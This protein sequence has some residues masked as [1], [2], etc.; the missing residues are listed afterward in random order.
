MGITQRGSVVHHFHPGALLH[1]QT[2]TIHEDEKHK[3]VISSSNQ[4][5][6]NLSLYH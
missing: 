4:L 1:H 3:Q 5:A 6:T 2:P